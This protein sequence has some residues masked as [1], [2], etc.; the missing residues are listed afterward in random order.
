MLFALVSDLVKQRFRAGSDGNT[1]N[2]IRKKK[3][4]LY[5]WRREKNKRKRTWLLSEQGEW[6]ILF[7]YH[8]MLQ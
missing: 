1:E 7:R 6:R 5:S 4:K 2:T 8:L 3:I